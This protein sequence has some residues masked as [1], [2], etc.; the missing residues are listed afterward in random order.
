MTVTLNQVKFT[1]ND[2]IIHRYL[3]RTAVA[4]LATLVWVLLTAF[5][6]KL[7]WSPG[8]SLSTTVC[9]AVTD[10]AVVQTVACF[11]PLYLSSY[12]DWTLFV[13]GVQLTATL[14]VVM[15]DTFTLVG[16]SGSEDNRTT[17]R[18]TYIALEIGHGR[19][20]HQTYDT[21]HVRHTSTTH[22]SK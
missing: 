16:G 2:T 12:E 7:Y 13:S 15:S 1:G 17:L 6:S 22:H 8:K 20:A 18:G 14:V 3:L 5:T 11:F 10:S 9:C 21:G 19:V 4:V